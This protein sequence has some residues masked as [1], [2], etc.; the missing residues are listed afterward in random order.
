M[1]IVWTTAVTVDERGG[2]PLSEHVT[3]TATLVLMT[4]VITRLP[5]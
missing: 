5:F 1:L 4:S 2:S 3:S